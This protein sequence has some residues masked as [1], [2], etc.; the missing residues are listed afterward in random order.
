MS[1]P[2]GGKF[3]TFGRI[4]GLLIISTSGGAIWGL[5]GLPRFP[6]F[7][8]IAMVPAGILWY[9][10]AYLLKSVPLVG[11]GMEWLFSLD[12]TEPAVDV[13]PQ[14]LANDQSDDMQSEFRVLRDNFLNGELP[15]TDYRNGV[16][17]LISYPPDGLN[18]TTSEI[19]E[20]VNQDIRESGENVPTI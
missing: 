15:V 8:L 12:T 11:E 19:R 6:G 20:T 7:W 3:G 2:I 14:V 5:I 4:A 13:D 18:E 1:R 17:K 16:R 9:G 10:L